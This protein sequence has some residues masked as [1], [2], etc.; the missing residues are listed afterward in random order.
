MAPQSNGAL[1]VEV[2]SQSLEAPGGGSEKTALA[3]EGAK[4]FRP[5]AP[6]DLLTV[7]RAPTFLTTSSVPHGVAKISLAK[8]WFGRDAIVQIYEQEERYRTRINVNYVREVQEE[9]EGFLRLAFDNLIMCA[10]MIHIR[11]SALY[12]AADMMHR[13]LSLVP[14]NQWLCYVITTVLLIVQ[15][16]E[17]TDDGVIGISSLIRIFFGEQTTVTRDD[18]LRCEETVLSILDH[19]LET[20]TPYLLLRYFS[21][22]GDLTIPE[23]YLCNYI[24]QLAMISPASALYSTPMLTAA[25]VSLARQAFGRPSWS[26]TLHYYTAFTEAEMAGARSYLVGLWRSHYE[27]ALAGKTSVAFKKF[28]S[29]GYGEVSKIAPPVK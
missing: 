20:V 26:P 17:P 14:V 22:A 11:E 4:L 23:N 15:K 28:T 19:N 24:T 3:P 12:L 10:N 27:A 25:A 29:V 16:Y 18:I 5:I 8:E 7:N 6:H 1:E 9:G 2:E 13:V 21:V